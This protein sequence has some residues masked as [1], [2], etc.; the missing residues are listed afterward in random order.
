[1]AKRV[2][3]VDDSAMMRKMIAKVIGDAGHQVAGEATNGEEA[4]GL[5]ERLR[6]DLVTMDITMR[7]MD[8]LS[9]AREIKKRDPSAR[10]LFLSNLDED[11]YR[12]QATQLGIGLVNKHR[13]AEIIDLVNAE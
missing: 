12:D 9:A 3:V 4:I 11:K 10:I 2:L 1:M 7:G 8:G 13:S 5:F 6:P